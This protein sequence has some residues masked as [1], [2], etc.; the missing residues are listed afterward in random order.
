ME[1]DWE[2]G[3]PCLNC[4]NCYYAY[5]IDS[6]AYDDDSIRKFRKVLKW[7]KA[8][9]YPVENGYGKPKDG[10]LSPCPGWRKVETR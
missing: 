10:P 2:V 8:N 7:T 5:R 3:V 4:Y 9:C 6:C 1:T